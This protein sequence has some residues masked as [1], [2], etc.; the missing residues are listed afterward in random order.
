MTLRLFLII[1]IMFFYLCHFCFRF[2]STGPL[3]LTYD[4]DTVHPCLLLSPDK[5]MVVESDSMFQYRGN[6]KRFVQCVNVLAAQG[7]QTGRHY[8]EVDVGT[9]P[10]WDLGVALETVD[11]RARVKLC[12]E[13]GYWTLRLRNGRY[14]A[15]TQPWTP[16][17][18]TSR[19]ER[20]GVFV[21]FE[22]R[23]VSFYNASTMSL[24][25][26]FFNGPRGKAFPFFSPCLKEPG[27]QAQ[28]IRLLHFPSQSL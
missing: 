4:E 27:Q 19:S 6:P 13:N 10:K 3:P 17:R 1:T 25:C 26:S 16:L 8:W 14:S 15:G 20:I 28:P 11:R 12:P 18:I 2:S 23:R 22:E 21:D 24:L 9:K 5:T 7:F